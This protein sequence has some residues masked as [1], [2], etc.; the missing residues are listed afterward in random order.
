MAARGL[1]AAANSEQAHRYPLDVL[2]DGV[3]VTHVLAIATLA[4]IIHIPGSERRD[5]SHLDGLA[6]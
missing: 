6:C 4:L 5:T 3:E 2:G 1:R